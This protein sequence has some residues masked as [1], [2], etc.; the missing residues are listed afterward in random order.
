MSNKCLSILLSCKCSHQNLL[1]QLLLV[2]L[3]DALSVFNFIAAPTRT[4]SIAFSP[5]RFRPDFSNR[6]KTRGRFRKEGR[7][8]N[9]TDRPNLRWTT[10]RRTRLPSRHFRPTFT[11]WIFAEIHRR[12]F[13]A[14]SFDFRLHTGYNFNPLPLQFDFQITVNIRRKGL[15]DTIFFCFKYQAERRKC[16]TKAS[17]FKRRPLRAINETCLF[18]RLD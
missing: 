11:S 6:W 10:N 18:S 16:G 7:F 1:N 5:R 17:A 14:L 15:W 12:S 13:C 4:W 8:R 2:T 3:I 9:S